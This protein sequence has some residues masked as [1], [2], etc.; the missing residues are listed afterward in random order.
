MAD[1]RH[2]EAGAGLAALRAAMSACRRGFAA[3]LVFSLFVN[4]LLLTVPLYMLQ[5]YDRVLNSR[6]LDTLLYLTLFAAIAL[7]IIAVVEIARSHAMVGLSTWLERRLS[8]LLLAESILAVVRHGRSPSAQPLRDLTAARGFIGGPAIFAILD[9]PWIPIYLAVIF[10]LHP[11]LGA[12][13]VGGG[14]LL[15]ALAVTNDLATRAQLARAGTLS[16]RALS[17]ADSAIRNAD[18]ILAM[19]M[20]HNLTARWN[21]ANAET[22]ELQ[23]R[24]S[25]RSSLIAAVSRF[26]RLTLQILG[27]GAGAWLV[28]DNAITAGVM[29]AGSI[30]MVRAMAPLDSSIASWRSALNARSAYGRIKENLEL[31]PPLGAAMPLPP[32]NGPLVVESLAY[33][34]PGASEPLLKGLAFRL[35]PGDSMGVIGPTAVGKTTLARLLVGNLRPISGRVRLDGADLTQWDSERLGRYVGYLPQTVELFAGTVC[36]NIARMSAGNSEAVIAAAKLAGVHDLILQL[37]GGYNCDI[38]EGGATLSGGQRQRIGLARAL[39]GNPQ[40]VV[41][42]EPNS[43]LDQPGEEALL[44]ALRGLKEARVTTIV[45]AH[46]P[47]VVRR[48]DKLLFL[49]HKCVFKFGTPNEVLPAATV[50]PRERSRL[51]VGGG[52]ANA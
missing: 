30:L 46:R 38:G 5:V 31:L 23:E 49:G 26:V 10:L 51:V 25:R 37:P 32:P 8:G 3:V 1:R 35:E 16:I 22:L 45:V 17:Q 28:L 29:I 14:I 44:E 9:V 24:A 21:R 52:R 33:Q 48:A 39:Y 12:L 47:N 43:N 20:M 36:E 2:G 19:G 11:I 7:L 15:L 4:V 18:V 42:D 27:L 40:L 13:T 50:L 34:N 41:L 6:S